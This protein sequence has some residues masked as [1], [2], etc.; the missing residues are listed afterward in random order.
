MKIN[1][2][3][4]LAAAV[5][6]S[7]CLLQTQAQPSGKPL[8]GGLELFTNMEQVP[9]CVPL[10]L[11]EYK[12]KPAQERARQV[13][14]L[15]KN[16]KYEIVLQGLFRSDSTVDIETYFNN[17][18]NYRNNK[19]QVEKKELIS[20]SNCFY[21]KGYMTGNPGSRFIDITWLRKEDIVKLTIAYPSK[22]SVLWDKR[23][24]VICS[25]NSLCD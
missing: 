19:K 5:L 9:Y 22:D 15:I 1:I 23:L 13:F 8:T 24:P 21:F 20:S 12:I 25:Y 18:D 14:S 10:P 16:R 6:L 4:P 7:C 3:Q 2:I 17:S 11:K